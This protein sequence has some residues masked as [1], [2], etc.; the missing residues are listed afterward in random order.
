MDHLQ[1]LEMFVAVAREGGFA[2]AARALRTSPPAVT[3]GIAA[4]EARLGVALFHRSTRAVSLTAEGAVFLEQARRIVGDLAEAERAV[5]G[6]RGVPHGQL[7]ITAP[8]QFGRMHVLP[9]VAELID[10][11][12]GLDVR[13]MLVDR[14]VRTVEEGIDVAVRIGPLADSSLMAIRIGAVRQVIVASASYLARHGAP[15]K[16]ADLGNHRL[17]A[18][19]GPRAANEWRFGPRQQTAIAP[20]LRVTT[21]DAAIAAAQAGVGIAN[22]LSYQ[23]EAELAAGRLI[24]VL[25]TAAPELLPI[26]LLFEASRGNAPST[27]AF[28]EAMRER[29]AG[30]RWA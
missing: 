29:A 10:R 16:P 15:E 26:S 1:T 3:R 23:V 24:E 6:S 30:Q 4:L 21:V 19:T 13:L 20:R 7:Y 8:V 12:V 11:H 22:L 28:I 5:T 2:A 17:I 27:R 25:R 14:N 18:S 9:A